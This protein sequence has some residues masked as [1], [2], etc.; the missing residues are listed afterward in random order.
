[1]LLIG[2]DGRIEADT[3]AQ[4]PAGTAFAH[5][6]LLD[7]ALQEPVAVLVT[8]KQRA[9][10]MVVVPVFA[11]DLIGYIGASIP[12]DDR[13]V[14]RLQQQ[15]TL[16]KSI[17][18]VAADSP[19]NYAV[20]ARGSDPGRLAVPLALRGSLPTAPVVADVGGREYVAQAVWLA[21][22]EAGPRVAAVLGFSVDDAL[23]PYRS[24][25]LAWAALLAFGLSVG[26]TC[27]W[28][29]AR[30]VSRPVEALAALAQRIAA[31]DYSLP[32]PPARTD[33]LGQLAGAFGNMAHAIRE[34]EAH[35]LHQGQP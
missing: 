3:T 6:D 35:I 31:G 25:G 29:I 4:W 19:G 34:R 20:L 33:E 14:R 1:M 7:R 28:L 24:V 22:P 10:W 32:P 11:P 15:S 26:L 21:G 30:S 18:L 12:V 2:V 9:Y 13:V 5:A 8:W 27:A 17:E 16:P 23:K